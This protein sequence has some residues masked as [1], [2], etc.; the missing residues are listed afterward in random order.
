MKTLK[1]SLLTLCVFAG[2]QELAFADAVSSQDTSKGFV[3]DSSL[4]VLLRNYY[5]NRDGKNG[6]ADR[7]D[8]S[9]AAIASFSSGFTQGTIGFGVDA[10]GS[11]ALKLDGGSG[12]TGLGNVKVDSDGHPEK[13]YGEIGGDIKARF[14]KTVIKWGEQAPKNPVFAPGGTR[15]IPQSATGWSLLSSEIPG[16]DIDA[17]HFTAGKSPTGT[18]SNGD[19]FANY[20][21]IAS[22]EADYLGAKYEVNKSLNVSLYASQLKDIWNQTYANAAYTYV[23]DPTQ[24]LG[25]NGTLYR[26]T[27]TGK[28]DAGKID[29]TTWSLAASYAFLVAHKIT[30]GFQKV[31]GDTPFDTIAFG[32]GAGGKGDSVVLPNAIQ[33][34]DFNGPGERSWQLRYDLNLASYG[35]PGLT[36]M[37]RYVTGSD[38]DGSKIAPGSAY[39]HLKYGDDG[40]HHETNLEAKYV[41][42]TGPAKDLSLRLRQA[43][44]RANKDEGEGDLSDTRLIVEYPISIF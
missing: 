28:A 35:V 8:W 21:K 9:Q 26:T 7:K 34:S 38:I 2:T 4:N 15:L 43:W 41:V 22:T 3:A 30:V 37:T 44:H 40:K 39:S 19:L 10:L 36:F 29:N 14:S 24:S 13:S 6:G 42:Q 1:L 11:V 25:L 31:H 17:G 5:W 16:L 23:I 27:D 12:T 32:N 20:A 18:N 33:Y